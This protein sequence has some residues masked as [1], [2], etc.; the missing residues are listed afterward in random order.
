M[1]M[2]V[3]DDPIIRMILCNIIR[4]DRPG[5]E[6]IECINGDDAYRKMRKDINLIFTDNNMPRLCGVDFIRKI[7]SNPDYSKIPIV[8]VSVEDRAEYKA[9][10]VELGIDG[11][12]CKPF[13]MS[14]IRDCVTRFLGAA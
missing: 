3:E 8:M 10:C 6:V 5:V 2:V 9:F 1:V 14:Q 7:K 4:H 11:W 13:L 12:V